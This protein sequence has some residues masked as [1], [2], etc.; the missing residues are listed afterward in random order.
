M[1]SGSIVVAAAGDLC[2]PE[3][4][5]CAPTADLAAA[6]QP[7]LVL[8]LGDNQ[9]EDGTLRDYRSSYGS[10]WGRFRSIT[11][12]VAGNHEWHT[13][14]AQGYLDYFGTNRYWYSY[15]RAGWHFVALDGTCDEDGGCGP[16]SP[17]YEWLKADLAG[18]HP[19]ILAYWHQP[20]WSSGTRHGSDASVGPFWDLLAA[21]GADLVLNG[22]EHNYERFAPQDPSG[23]A[24]P[25]GI[26]EIVAGT[27]GKGQY[28][29]GIPIAN[30][31]ARSEGPGI[32]ELVLGPDHWRERFILTDGTIADTASGSC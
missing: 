27:G 12:P 6:I 19:C 2:L 28:P 22:H 10:T 31:L 32:V 20:R 29:F 18:A 4:A 21:A 16:G 5:S 13:T 11:R 30:S 17:Q 1:P 26:V 9:Y 23:V 3:P 25:S 8:V 14:D 24:D 15:D 7:D